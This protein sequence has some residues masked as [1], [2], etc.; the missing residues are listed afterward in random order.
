MENFETAVRAVIWGLLMCSIAQ[1]GRGDEHMIL[2]M[3]R[4]KIG[5]RVRRE[6]SS[7]AGFTSIG[8]IVVVIP[9]HHQLEI[10]DEYEVDFGANGILVAYDNQLNAA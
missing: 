5:D 9:N 10:F 3:A 2:L 8:T 6:M 1:R 4:F 7:G